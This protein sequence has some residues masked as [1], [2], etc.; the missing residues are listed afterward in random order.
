MASPQDFL[1]NLAHGQSIALRPVSRCHGLGQG[2]AAHSHQST[3]EGL[4]AATD[5]VGPGTKS[6]YQPETP[7]RATAAASNHN[8]VS[9]CLLILPAH[10]GA[11]THF[12]QVFGLPFPAA[13][14]RQPT[15]LP[16]MAEWGSLPIPQVGSPPLHPCAHRAIPEELTELLRLFQPH[17]RVRSHAERTVPH[18]LWLRLSINRLQPLGKCRVKEAFWKGPVW[19]LVFFQSPLL[20]VAFFPSH[21]TPVRHGAPWPPQ[22]LLLGLCLVW[23]G[24]FYYYVV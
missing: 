14:P 6:S 24:F 15:S 9:P 7:S 2:S 10:R 11:G 3:P 1:R 13:L 8:H 22:G 21:E 5:P 19:A 18:C 12:C 16:D 17:G 4:P 23:E 20:P